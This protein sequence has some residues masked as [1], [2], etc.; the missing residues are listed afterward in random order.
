MWERKRSA[1]A[2][3]NAL[4]RGYDELYGEEQKRKYFEVIKRFKIEGKV[5]DVGCGTGLFCKYVNGLYVGLDI[6]EGMIRKCKERCENVVIADAEHLPFR[7]KAFDICVSFTVLQDL[8]NPRRAVEEMLRVCRNV[9][10]SSMKGKGCEGL[11][12]VAFSYPDEICF[13][14]SDLLKAFKR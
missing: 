5:L 10:V 9:I 8:P 4:S 11:E 7:D 12:A 3:Y 13:A 1:V 14:S 6:S 2:W